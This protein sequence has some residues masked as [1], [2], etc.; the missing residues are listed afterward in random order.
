MRKLLVA[1][2]LLLF[3]ADPPAPPKQPV[4]YSHKQHIALG[5]Q[6]KNCHT[7]PEPGEMMGI[8][9]VK[10]CMGC[11]TSVKKDS[12]HIQT[13]AKHAGE[14]TEPP[15]VRVYRIPSYVFFS[16]K[17]HLATGAKCEI[18][19]G[20]V[21]TREVLWKETNISMGGCMECHRQNKASNDCAY[22][23]EPRQ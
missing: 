12:P 21:A 6:C 7:N 17:A 18:C 3:A 9:A 14:K 22:C 13:L 4:P 23:H 5:L 20:P 19:H 15:W 16:H 8:P 2:P 11:H 10:V 1:L